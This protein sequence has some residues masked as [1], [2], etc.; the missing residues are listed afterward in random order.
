MSNCPHKV[1]DCKPLGELHDALGTARIEASI[2]EAERND[3]RA[4][5]AKLRGENES[6]MAALQSSHRVACEQG[7]RLVAMETGGDLR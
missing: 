5:V 7:Q 1:K 3:L 2:I 6:L 4:E